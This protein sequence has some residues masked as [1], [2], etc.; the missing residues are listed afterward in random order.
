MK[1]FLYFIGFIFA[2]ITLLLSHDASAI[3]SIVAS[4]F[5][6]AGLVGMILEDSGGR[7]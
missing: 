6:S 5:I 2:L 3:T 4:S 1:Y 7:K